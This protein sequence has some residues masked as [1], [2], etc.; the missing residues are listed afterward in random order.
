MRGPMARISALPV[1]ALAAVL[2]AAPVRADVATADG[3]A[4]ALSPVETVWRGTQDLAIY[5]LG[6]L[7]VRYRYGGESPERGLDC[8]GLVRY[9]F[10]QVTGVTLPRTSRELAKVGAPVMRDDL[11]VGDLVFFDTRRFA[12]SHVGIYLGDDRFIHAPSRGSEVQISELDNRYWRRHFNGARRLIG[13]LPG[14]IPEAAAGVPVAAPAAA[15][16]R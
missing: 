6:L 8:S 5:A 15:L 7:G 4:P 12:F 14:L 1:L 11:Q 3:A 2:T 13:V 16:E 9:V 10:G